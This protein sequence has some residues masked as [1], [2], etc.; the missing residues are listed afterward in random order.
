[1]SNSQ[2]CGAVAAARCARLQA[3]A[4]NTLLSNYGSTSACETSFT[5]SCVNALAAP[6]NG[7]TAANTEACAQAIPGWACADYQN[8]QNIPTPCQQ[9]KGALASGTS[10]AFNGQ[11][12]SGYCQIPLYGRCGTC[13]AQPTAGTDCSNL[14]NCG[15]G[16]ECTE[17]TK[18]CVVPQGSGKPCAPGMPCGYELSC[19]GANADAGTMGTCMAAGTTAGVTCDPKLEAAGGCAEGQGLFC[20]GVT[21]TCQAYAIASGGEPCGAVDGGAAECTGAS[22]CVRG[23]DGGPR[24]CVAPAAEGNGCVTPGNDGPG[25]LAPDKCVV[26]VDGGTSGT[27]LQTTAAACM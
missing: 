2:A 5:T 8:D 6:S 21:K 15:P 14:A 19:V 22:R 18:T 26:T 12:Q 17:D 24:T 10:C 4:P 7:N 13:E 9:Q 11:C 27:C 3:C 16:L 25:C 1:V 20:D 23:A